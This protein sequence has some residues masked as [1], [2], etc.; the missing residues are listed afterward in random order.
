MRPLLVLIRLKCSL[1]GNISR[2]VAREL[3]VT[4]NFV[5]HVKGRGE[6]IS[7]ALNIKGRV[8]ALP[9][10]SCP[11]RVD[12]SFCLCERSSILRISEPEEQSIAKMLA[13]ALKAELEGYVNLYTCSDAPMI[14]TCTVSP[15]SC[16]RIL[17]TSLSTTH[18][19]CN[20]PHVV[21]FTPTG[22]LSTAMYDRRCLDCMPPAIDMRLRR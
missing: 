18:S 16:P 21:K 7:Y 1:G 9:A 17:K 3:S 2:N 19:K 8:L 14:L 11:L 15:T 20:A 10:R 4:A 13:L 5:L 12:G 22:S 6:G